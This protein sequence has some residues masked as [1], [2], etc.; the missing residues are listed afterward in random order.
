[1]S[2]DAINSWVK[3][4]KN[5]HSTPVAAGKQGVKVVRAPQQTKGNLIMQVAEAIRPHLM[6]M[7]EGV[8]DAEGFVMQ[9]AR[10]RGIALNVA[11]GI[12]N[13]QDIKG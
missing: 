1:M 10:V 3:N 6:K 8:R 13:Q 9:P 12:V 2:H 4:A 11:Q 5:E 7:F